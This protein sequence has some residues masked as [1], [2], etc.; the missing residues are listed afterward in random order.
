MPPRILTSVLLPAPF[1]P[2]SAWT[3]PAVSARSTSLSTSTAAKRLVI[4]RNSIAGATR[5]YPGLASGAQCRAEGPAAPVWLKRSGPRLTP[6]PLGRQDL[7]VVVLVVVLGEL[8]RLAGDDLAVVADSVGAGPL[9]FLDGEGIAGLARDLALGE[10]LRRVV[11]DV[12]EL[13]RVPQV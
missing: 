5:T 13:D 6:R 12:A 11:G 3:L 9:A 2:A 1:S 4:P 10:V 7:E 8:Q